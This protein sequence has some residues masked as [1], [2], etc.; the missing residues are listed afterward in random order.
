MSQTSRTVMR[1]RTALIHDWLNQQGGAE[2]VLMELHRVFPSAPIY[3]SFYEPALVDPAFRHLDIRHTWLQQFP[4]WRSNHQALLPLYP[5]AFGGLRVPKADLVLSNASAFC[6][7]I[8][9]APGAVHVCY[10]LTPTRFLWMPDAYLAGERAPHWSRVLLPPLLAWA[11]RWDRNAAGRVTQFLAISRAVA[12]RIQRFYGRSS[13]IVYPPVD[14]DRFKPTTDVGDALLIVSRLIP[15][16][17]IDLAVRACTDLGLPLR[18]VGSGRAEASLR[19]LA[20]PTVRFLGRLPDRDVSVEMARCRALLFPGD[21]D[22]GI[23]PVEAQAAGRPVV[24]YGS[25]GALDTVIDG[26]TGILFREQTVESLG[27]ALRQV[28]SMTFDTDAL[29]A[30]ARR[31]SREHFRRT[32]LEAVNDTLR[33]HGRPP[34]PDA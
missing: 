9:P 19:A 6:K 24:A 7:G 21:E 22:F 3:T 18:I 14:V 4:L 10:C 29:M 34:V 30:N 23:T 25:G 5:L 8:R 1:P 17:R 32:L 13:R 15:Y 26:T 16:K 12:D 31:F 2:N 20:G 11:R 28:Q 33:A 27:A